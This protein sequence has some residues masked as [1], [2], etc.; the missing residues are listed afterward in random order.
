MEI[1][2]FWPSR[3][4]QDKVIGEFGLKIPEWDLTFHKMKLIRTL[5]GGHFVAGPTYKHKAKDGKE[6]YREYWS[7]GKNMKAR[8]TEKAMEALKEYLKKD[9]KNLESREPIFL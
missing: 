1:L 5:N 4:P 6:E 3:D 8:F 9:I 7:F 2:Y